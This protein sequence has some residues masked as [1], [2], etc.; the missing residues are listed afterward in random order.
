MLNNSVIEMNQFGVYSYGQSG[1]QNIDNCNFKYNQTGIYIGKNWYSIIKNCNIDSNTISGIELNSVSNSSI[2]NCN[3]NNNPIGLSMIN[4]LGYIDSNSYMSNIISGNIIENNT[5]GFE[6]GTTK[7]KIYCNKICNNLSYNLKYSTSLNSNISNNYWCDTDSNII[8]KSIFDGNDSLNIGIVNIMPLD[9]VQCY[10]CRYIFNYFDRKFPT[11]STCK[12][13]SVT[14]NPNNE[15]PPYTY[16]WNTTPAQTTQTATGLS[17][18]MYTVLITDAN[19]CSRY[20]SVYIDNKLSVEK[21]I[22]KLN[23]TIFPNPGSD[24]IVIKLPKFKVEMRLNIFNNLG[25]LIHSSYITE[26]TKD[27]DVSNLNSGVYF[28]QI[29]NSDYFGSQKFIKH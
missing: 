18:G 2:L 9:T 25:Q 6:L 24:N 28:I 16:L 29:S 17:N 27:I 10:L 23:F 19:G 1:T 14:S 13:G 11:C 22:N 4:L 3:I 5:I 7:D 8:Q 20:D 26:Q 12:D 15:N 21:N